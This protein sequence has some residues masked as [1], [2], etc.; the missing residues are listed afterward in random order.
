MATPSLR[1][2]KRNLH[3]RSILRTLQCDLVIRDFRHTRHHYRGKTYSA[4]WVLQATGLIPT[5]L[6]R[7][8]YTSSCQIPHQ[9]MS[10]AE[11]QTSI[12]SKSK[13]SVATIFEWRNL[14]CDGRCKSVHIF[15]TIEF[16]EFCQL[17][18]EECTQLWYTGHKRLMNAPNCAA[19]NVYG[20]W[21]Y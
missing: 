1:S 3:F 19:L 17:R 2:S 5:A 6:G 15:S 7:T 13:H 21:M 14:I 20:W 10:P 11:R 4:A 18:Y 16:V 9:Q 8:P 12:F